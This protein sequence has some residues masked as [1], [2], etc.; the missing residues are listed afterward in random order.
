MW[1]FVYY[2]REKFYNIA[3]GFL[4]SFVLRHRRHI[5]PSKNL[6]LAS[7][8]AQVVSFVPVKPFQP[9]LIFVC[10]ARAYYCGANITVRIDSQSN[11]QIMHHDASVRV[12]HLAQLAFLSVPKKKSFII[13]DTWLSAAT[14]T[15]ASTRHQCSSDGRLN[16]DCC[17]CHWP[18]PL[19]GPRPRRL[20]SGTNFI[21]LFTTLIYKFRNKLKCLS[22]ASFSSLV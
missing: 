13:S 10:K 14:P 7:V 16:P 9:S 6:I 1:N 3:I 15:Q 20:Q 21:K 17:R 4:L 19:R 11:L 2:V 5:S 18:R 8:F 12:E 22:L